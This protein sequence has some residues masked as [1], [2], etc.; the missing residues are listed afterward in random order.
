MKSELIAVVLMFLTAQ[1]FADISLTVAWT[2]GETVELSFENKGQAD[3]ELEIPCEGSGWCDRY[4]DVEAEHLDGT[5]VRKSILYSS[6]IPSFIVR[7]KVRGLY[8]HRIKPSAYLS[9][10]EIDKLK[11]LRISY[12]NPINEI[13]TTSDWVNTASQRVEPT[14]NNVQFSAQ[15]TRQR[16]LPVT[17][18]M[19]SKNKGDLLKG[20]V[21]A[22]V[23]SA[24]GLFLIWK[25]I[26]GDIIRTS[27]DEALYPKWAYI[28]SGVIVLIMPVTVFVVRLTM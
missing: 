24:F 19:D 6:G 2:G 12:T 18:G 3:I 27:A 7:L 28:L 26:V 14:L 22:I 13:K 10:V 25:G 21:A 15:R 1:T 17:L 4:F 8:S 23:L 16:G 11:R 20:K 5:R 9:G